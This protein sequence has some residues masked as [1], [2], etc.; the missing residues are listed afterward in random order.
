[1]GPRRGTRLVTCSISLFQ[2]SE[3]RRLWRDRTSADPA[4]S[5]LSRT[6]STPTPLSPVASAG[7]GQ[8]EQP[9]GRIGR[10]LEAH[11]RVTCKGLLAVS[12]AVGFKVQVCAD[13]R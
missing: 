5:A 9:S 8:S 6:P 12:P 3:G 13:G 7:S 2:G 1:M 10:C 4:P 11:A